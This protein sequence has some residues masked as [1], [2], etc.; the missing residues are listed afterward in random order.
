MDYLALNGCFP[1]NEWCDIA[2]YR[3]SEQLRELLERYYIR[4]YCI[5]NR[6]DRY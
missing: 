5:P 1:I 6:K 2:I 4:Y 3:S